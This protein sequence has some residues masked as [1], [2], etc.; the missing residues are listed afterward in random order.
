MLLKI[1]LTNPHTLMGYGER[2]G[3]MHKGMLTVE[4][5]NELILAINESSEVRR[6]EVNSLKDRV[7]ALE[8]ELKA[9]NK[10][11]NEFSVFD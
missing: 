6:K 11:P 7:K 4:D 5:Y 3:S 9:M 2:E 10:A 1:N 8:Q